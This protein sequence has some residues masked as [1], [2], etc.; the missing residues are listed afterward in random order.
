VAAVPDAV[1]GLHWDGRIVIDATNEF[2]PSDLNGW[3]SSQVLA[4][5]VPGAR[6]VKAANTLALRCSVRT[7][8]SAGAGA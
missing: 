6:V 3:T 7:R 5:L 8:T 2:D 1:Q 4:D